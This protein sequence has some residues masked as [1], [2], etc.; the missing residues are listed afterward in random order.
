[1]SPMDPW[2]ICV[3]EEWDQPMREYIEAIRSGKGRILE[4]NQRLM[5]LGDLVIRISWTTGSGGTIW[6][7]KYRFI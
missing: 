6:G 2:S 3:T 5:F 7:F 4:A 1:M